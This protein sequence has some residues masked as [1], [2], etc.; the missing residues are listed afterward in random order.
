MTY[1]AVSIGAKSIDEAAE[2]IKAAKKAGAEMLELRTDYLADLDVARMLTVLAAAGKTALP[3][4]VTCRDKAQGGAADLPLELRTRILVEA[5]GAGADFI[6]CEFDNFVLTDTHAKITAALSARDG[7]GL[8]LSAHQFDSPFSNPAGVYEEIVRTED[9]AIPKLACTA[10]HINDCFDTLDILLHKDRDAIVLC[11]GQAGL[12]TRL[13]AKK[14]GGFATFACSDAAHATAPGQLTVRR[15]KELYRWDQIDAETEVFGVIGSPVAHS[16]SPAVFNACFD[17]QDIN[18]MYLPLLV[19]GGKEELYVF[20]NNAVGRGGRSGAGGGLGFG[21]F[22][23]TL[24]HKSH[25]RD[26]VNHVGEFVEPLAEAIGAANT[27]KVGF[28]GIVSGYNTDYAGAMDALTSV[29]QIGRHD[30]HSMKVAVIGAGGVARAVVA[31]LADVGAHITIYNRTVAK[32]QALADEFNCCCAPLDRLKRMD[33]QVVINCTSI[34]MFPNVE[35]S[36]VGAECIKANMAVFDTVYNPLQTKLLKDAQATG[37]KTING[38]EMF[39]RQAMAQ[40]R[41]FIGRDADPDVMRK[42]VHKHLADSPP[43]ANT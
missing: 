32:A 31:G 15:F 37:A 21:G 20:V 16:L 10:G 12:I 30:L 4:I 2:Q 9:K 22:S 39:V 19:E 40:Y 14:L 27:L 8:I 36:P 34:G 5:V 43:Q 26:Y 7:A 38:A 18:A 6:D 24:P 13:L 23:V 11:M 28:G 42:T 1:L 3:V 41:I 35:A 29:L 25:A 17:A 33:A